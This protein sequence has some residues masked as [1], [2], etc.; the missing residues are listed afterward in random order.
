MR[1]VIRVAATCGVVGLVLVGFTSLHAAQYSIDP[2]HSQVIFQVNHLGVSNVYGRFD[3]VAGSFVYDPANP[4]ASSF[5]V[6]IQADSVDTGAEK[7]D[8]HV[9]GPDF[10]DAKQ[11]PVIRLKS[12][13]LA[14]KGEHNYQA[15]ADLEL[16]GVTKEVAV[17]IEHVGSGTDPRG[18]HREG[19]EARFVVDRMAHGVSFMPD[20]L[21]KEVTVLVN[22]E[23]V[24]QK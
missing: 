20:G 23:G 18:N 4:G 11:F 1:A 7:R 16:H 14:K 17:D 2:V 21:G 24:Q 10:L 5:E 8:Q 12:K 9:T 13:S 19:F 15:K 3:N 6:T 22:I